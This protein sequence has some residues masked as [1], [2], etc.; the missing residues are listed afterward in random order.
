MPLITALIWIGFNV[1][2]TEAI[3]NQGFDTL[4]VLSEVGNSDIEDMINNIRCALEN[5][6]PGNITFPFLAIKHL[7]DIRFWSAES[8]CTSSWSF[9]YHSCYKAYSRKE[10][11]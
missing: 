2:T 5:N 6:T 8:V 9:D 7:K 11:I 3:I 10:E 1:D 4:E